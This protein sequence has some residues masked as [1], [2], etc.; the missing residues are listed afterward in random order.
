[1]KMSLSSVEPPSDEQKGFS[2]EEKSKTSKKRVHY[3]KF[4][5]GGFGIQQ[6]TQDG[7]EQKCGK[8]HT[9]I[10]VSLITYYIRCL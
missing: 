10:H 3:M 9:V 4:T 2:L 8:M 1:M 6:L 7:S 5:K